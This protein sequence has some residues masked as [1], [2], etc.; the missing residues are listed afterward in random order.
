MTI[1]GGWAY[2]GKV[3]NKK[4]D[5]K[6]GIIISVI[7]LAAIGVGLWVIKLLNT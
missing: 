5:L 4:A 7:F 1:G 3:G 6:F 2:S